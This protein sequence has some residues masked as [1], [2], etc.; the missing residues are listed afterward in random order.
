MIFL[1]V[2]F[3]IGF[4]IGLI[5]FDKDCKKY[6][7]KYSNLTW[8]SYCNMQEPYIALS[9]IIIMWPVILIIYLIYCICIIP[10]NW[11]KKHNGI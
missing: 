11:I 4:I 3:I 8:Q 2:Y 6:K 5:Q 10:I 1:I 9:A 7:E